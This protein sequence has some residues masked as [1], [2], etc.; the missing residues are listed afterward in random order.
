MGMTIDSLP[1]P[2]VIIDLSV[3]R[4]NIAKMADHV[5]VLGVALRPHWKTTKSVEIARMQVEAGAVGHT[6]ATAAEASVLVEAGFRDIFWA[7]PPVGHHRV[8]VAMRLAQHANLI[9]GPDSVEAARPVAK[10]AKELGIEIQARLEVDTGLKRTGVELDSAL[11]VAKELSQMPGIRLEGI[12]THEGHVQGV[13]N[14]S[15]LR[16]TTGKEAGRV[17]AEVAG[18]I[19]EAGIELSS[20]SV[21]S[22][23]G[24]RSAPTIAGVTEARPGTYVYGDENQVAIGTVL[25]E[26]VAVTVLSS[27]VSVQRDEPVVIDAG[28]KVMSSDG[29]M[30]SDARIGTV[31]SGTGG[32]VVK[33][34]E[35][36]GFLYGSTGL[37]VGDRL[38]IRP[39][40]ACGLI[41][42]HSRVF[43]VEEGVVVDQWHTLA[44][45]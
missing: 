25:P 35:E 37:R 17:L 2:A 39:N 5:R 10:A 33:G 16:E 9:I 40:H 26:E 18:E 22:T 4:M 32:V 31:I 36:H 13:G 11:R 45:H 15:A 19:R 8:A 3:V 42:M 20:V 24:V 21:G 34:H 7:Y 38:Q 23:A 41:N 14:N 1:T 12:F 43:V 28:I 44:R 29:S 6:V 27:V 30:H